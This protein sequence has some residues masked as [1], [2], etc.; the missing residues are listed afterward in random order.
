[1]YNINSDSESGFEDLYPNRTAPL[2]P[3]GFGDRLF[4]IRFNF[5]KNSSAG[6]VTIADDNFLN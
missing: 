2:W 4:V 5:V 3:A 1:M 6:T